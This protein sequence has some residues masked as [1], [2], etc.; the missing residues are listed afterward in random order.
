[1]TLEDRINVLVELGQQIQ[2][3]KEDLQPIIRKTYLENKWLTETNCQKAL[4][5]I[6]QHFLQKDKLTSWTEQYEISDQFSKKNVGLILAGNIPLVGFHDVLAVFISGHKSLIKLSD[7]DKNLIPQLIKWM[8]DINPKTTEYFSF[9]DILSN[10]DAVIATG[11]NN[12]AVHFEYY[13][14]HVPNII[15]RNRNGVAV[16]DGQ[17]TK[18]TLLELGKDIFDYFGL[19]CRN[20]SKLY[21]PKEYDFNFLMETLHE[22]NELVLH[23]KY[24][25]NFDYNYAIFLLNQDPFLANGCIIVKETKDIAT[26]IAM[27]GYE[28]YDN[29]DSLSKELDRR[30]EEIQCIVSQANIEGAQTIEP[31]K[32]QQPNLTDYADGVDTLSFL[33]GLN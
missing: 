12:T 29:Y 20:V 2:N 27:V 10:Y 6:V 14:K 23:N 32:A 31:G 22:Y 15:R 7:K 28:Y 5:G 24:K 19:G 9:L 13:F 33:I 30:A 16:L 8:E 4:K 18:E 26:R 25:N 17:E 1:M 21:V 3:R 11:S